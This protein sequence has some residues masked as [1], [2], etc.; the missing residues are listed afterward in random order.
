M[1]NKRSDNLK[2]FA[3][4]EEVGESLKKIE[5]PI[6]NISK[7]DYRAIIRT[8]LI[9]QYIKDNPYK[10]PYSIAKATGVNYATISTTISN[11]E[12]CKLVATRLQIGENNRAN[13][14]VYVPEVEE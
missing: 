6:K 2:N 3:L 5:T 10:T 11:F 4:R 8:H 9:L 13:K 14:L 7:V 1:N 12:Y